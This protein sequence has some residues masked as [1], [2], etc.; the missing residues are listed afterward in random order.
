MK[1]KSRFIFVD[2]KTTKLKQI[3]ISI[4]KIL[5]GLIA[6][7]FLI[8]SSLKISTDLMLQF[9]RNSK[10]SQLEKRN[11]V[12]EKQ[13]K[14]M[15]GKIQL[16]RNQIDK[17]EELDDRLRTRLDIPKLDEDVRQVGIGGSDL[18]QVL[19]ID[20]GDPDLKT[21]LLKNRNVLDR[22]EREVK[23]EMESYEKLLTT[24][25]RKEDSLRFLPAIK[26]VP[27]GRITDG[28]GYRRHP[29]LKR[30][31]FHYGLDFSSDRGT[32]V[33]AT[34]DGYVNFTGINGGYGKFISINHKYGYET[35]YG[36]LQKIYVRNGQFVKRGDKIGEVGNT[37]RSTA[38]HLHYEVH[39]KGKAVDPSQFYFHDIAFK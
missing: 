25:E 31:L 21:A 3:N 27:G 13:L 24:M 9:T 12:L 11:N 7:S 5:I 36:H 22:L 39:Y 15:S 17:I 30:I 10:I 26:P 16:I 8:G 35:K 6:L 29:I 23:L 19:Q 18:S 14:H 2:S 32:P 37:G 4:P 38:P 33:L 20:L 1:K 28:F 34:A